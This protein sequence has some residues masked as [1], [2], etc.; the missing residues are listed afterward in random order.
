M[1]DEELVRAYSHKI[2]VPSEPEIIETKRWTVNGAIRT[3]D[4]DS[5]Y[6]VDPA[7][8]KE[9][10]RFLNSIRRSQLLMLM[11]ARASGKSTRLYWLMSQLG[12]D[13]YRCFIVSFEGVYVKSEVDFWQS[14]G[15]ALQHSYKGLR[16]I[17]SSSDFLDAFK[18]DTW[19][20]KIVIFVDEFDKLYNASNEIRDACLETFREIK[21]NNHLYAIHSIV[22]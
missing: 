11:G 8:N 20:Q 6:Y 19:K 4:I 7:E 22:A 1:K 15:G 18:Q 3:K 16:D 14:F 9:N 21:N 12:K 5:F 2:H 17:R 13:G 10:Q